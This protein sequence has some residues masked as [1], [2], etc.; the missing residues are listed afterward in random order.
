MIKL[1][2]KV[3]LSNTAVINDDE[4]VTYNYNVHVR[5]LNKDWRFD[6]KQNVPDGYRLMYSSVGTFDIICAKSNPKGALEKDQFVLPSLGYMGTEYILS[7]DSEKE[8]Y[9]F[10]RNM[11]DT[12]KEWA[13]YWWGFTSDERSRTTIRDDE[14]IIE[15]TA[16]YE[17]TGR[18]A[19][20]WV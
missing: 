13:D 3:R 7:F 11:Y 19:E 18:V 4:T 15:Y 17:S 5:V 16:P 6:I 14:W 9:L 1:R 10:V 20:S 8:R 2:V 12:L